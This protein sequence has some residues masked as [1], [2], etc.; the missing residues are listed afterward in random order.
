MA[1]KEYMNIYIVKYLLF[2][3]KRTSLCRGLNLAS[4]INSAGLY[5]AEITKAELVGDEN[6]FQ[7][8]T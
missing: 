6:S 5:A 2:G 4:A 3:E 1:T 7:D 8:K